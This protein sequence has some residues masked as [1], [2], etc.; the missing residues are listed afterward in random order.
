LEKSHANDAFIIAGGNGQ[1][2]AKEY[3]VSQRRRNNRSLQVN[4]KGYGRSVRRKRYD[5]Q[6]GDLLE[7]KGKVQRSRG[8]FNYGRYVLVDGDD[9]YWK[10]EDVRLVKH[11]K[12]V[13]FN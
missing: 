6:P 7:N 2:R 5:F 11:G 10:T 1:K 8:V 3:E 4:R 9:D 12:G 13:Q